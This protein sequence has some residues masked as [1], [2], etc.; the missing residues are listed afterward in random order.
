MRVQYKKTK[1]WPLILI[2]VLLATLIASGLL[3]LFT[4]NWPFA[5]STHTKEVN[6]PRIDYSPPTDT[7][8]ESSQNG[9]KQQDTP[10]KP[11][12]TD[13]GK[14]KVS[15]NI[16]YADQTSESS[17]DIRAFT[18]DIIEGTGTCTAT[19]AQ[20]D[21]TIVQSSK[22]FIDASSTICEPIIIPK[23]QFP[24]SGTWTLTVNYDSPSSS[25]LSDKIEVAL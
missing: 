9:K 25:G 5:D 10:K 18:P 13:T 15:I 8:I 1:K 7:E 3:A 4:N 12:Q 17:V 21:K 6:T 11:Q 20:G 22:G 16:S 14:Q 24:T 19:L 2:G 23:A